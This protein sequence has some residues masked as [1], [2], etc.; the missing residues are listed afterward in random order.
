VTPSRPTT[1]RGSKRANRLDGRAEAQED[2]PPP[3]KRSWL[4]DPVEPPLVPFTIPEPKPSSRIGPVLASMAV[5]LT[6]VALVVVMASSASML[7][8]TGAAREPG[9]NQGTPAVPGGSETTDKEP[10]SDVVTAL[11]PVTDAVEPTLGSGW[12]SMDAAEFEPEDAPPVGAGCG[13]GVGTNVTPTG[14]FGRTWS[15]PEA[16]SPTPGQAVLRV[17]S[18]DT[19]E[20]VTTDLAAEDELTS[21]VC[22][23]ASLDAFRPGSSVSLAE[24]RPPGVGAG[25]AGYRMV[26]VDMA[27]QV[28]AVTDTFIVG[29]GQLQG[30]LTLSR[31]CTGWEL[32][33]ERTVVATLL[34][35][36]ATAQ[37]LPAGDDVAA[38]AN[39]SYLDEGVDPCTLLLAA[40]LVQ[41]GLTAPGPVGEIEHGDLGQGTCVLTTGLTTVTVTTARAG[42]D[43][44]A[45]AGSEPVTGLGDRAEWI[46]TPEGGTVNVWRPSSF[47]AITVSAAASDEP[48]TRQM[49]VALATVAGPR[50]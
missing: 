46:R 32:T 8:R 27:G 39:G 5:L 38:A 30:T 47:L 28:Q 26:S 23:T 34:E 4:V 17:A 22:S 37:G 14:V 12:A 6:V 43:P 49:A 13:S 21:A 9:A 33:N 20:D 50:T 7:G 2:A 24:R 29:I 40:D 48:T 45:T 18:F 44:A 41:V 31:C 42:Y 15:L 36:L 16:G 19:A 1:P 25:S 10:E 11:E 3:E 35:E